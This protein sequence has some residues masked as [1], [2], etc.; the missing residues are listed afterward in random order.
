MTCAYIDPYISE[1]KKKMIADII[2]SKFDGTITDIEDNADIIIKK[3]IFIMDFTKAKKKTY[4]IE[5]LQMMSKEV[6]NPFSFQSQY[7]CF[8]NLY[9][10]N[11]SF[12]LVNCSSTNQSH[13]S[14][15]IRMM[16]GEITTD[17]PD[18]KLTDKDD[19]DESLFS[20]NWLIELQQSNTYIY[21]ELFQLKNIHKKRKIKKTKE[22]DFIQPT[23]EGEKFNYSKEFLDTAYKIRQKNK[24]SFS[25]LKH[26]L[27]SM[28]EYRSLRNENLKS[29]IDACKIGFS[30]IR[31]VHPTI[32]LYH[33]YKLETPNALRTSFNNTLLRNSVIFGNQKHSG[34]WSE[35]ET[36]QL[37]FVLNQGKFTHEMFNKFGNINW[38]FVSSHI[39]GRCPKSCEDKYRLMIREG[40]CEEIEKLE[41]PI[42]V[43]MYNKLLHKAFTQEQE[44]EILDEILNRIDNGVPVTKFTISSIAL[45]MFYCPLNLCIKA[46]INSYLD[47]RE[48]PYDK[49][50]LL[51]IPDL[52]TQVDKLLPLAEEDPDLLMVKYGVKKF[53]GSITWVGK[54]MNR[55]S[56]VH[57]EAH[58]EKRGAIKDDEVDEFF[59]QLADALVSI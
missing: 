2:V 39:S 29:F 48:W 1:K 51:N 5:C 46:I 9:L 59:T 36:R 57:R 17:I 43:T 55:H 54:F 19:D 14:A 33:D 47:R 26:V 53:K 34:P 3:N 56:L 42:P 24:Y 45:D 18:Y 50:G 21:P 40:S 31:S 49:N 58:P 7:N 16:G 37:L 6:I 10:R 11:K 32:D 38:I 44:M 22:K 23:Q 27:Q 13:Y 30:M 8:I 52:K 41:E 35:S 15:L 28:P 20:V 12:S 25:R 4:S